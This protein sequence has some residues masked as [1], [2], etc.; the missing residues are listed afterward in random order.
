M[1]NEGRWLLESS[2]TCCSCTP[3]PRAVHTWRGQRGL[4]VAVPSR[5]QSRGEESK[6]EQSRGSRAHP[7]TWEHPGLLLP[8]PPRAP[9]GAA[10][11]RSPNHSSARCWQLSLTAPTS[12]LPL[13]RGVKGSAGFNVPVFYIVLPSPKR[14]LRLRTQHRY[15]QI[16]LKGGKG[17]INELSYIPKSIFIAE[18]QDQWL[19]IS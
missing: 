14:K 3:G 2:A 18:L 19:H 15:I 8:C 9:G 12:W 7:S 11:P 6:E 17:S 5:E 10:T 13:W 16:F 4:Q 1:P